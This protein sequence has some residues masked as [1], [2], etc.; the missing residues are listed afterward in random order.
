MTSR[1]I[2]SY[3]VLHCFFS[4]SSVGFFW[5]FGTGV[6]ALAAT[7]FSKS[8][9]SGTAAVP[10]WAAALGGDVQPLVELVLGDGRFADLGDGSG[11]HVLAAAGEGGDAECGGGR[12]RMTF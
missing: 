9:G 8:G 3:S 1:L 12:A 2:A 4:A 10:P 5:P 11:G 6:F 7:H